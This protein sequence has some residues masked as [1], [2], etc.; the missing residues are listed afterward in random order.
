MNNYPLKG[1]NLSQRLFKQGEKLDVPKPN[2]MFS[3]AYK[4]L[5]TL[6]DLNSDPQPSNNMKDQMPA[7]LSQARMSTFYQ[8]NP[9]STLTSSKKYGVDTMGG[10]VIPDQPPGY[11]PGN[12]LR[13]N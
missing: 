10:E 7:F 4:N 2:N 3:D 8:D 1:E 13:R 12:I 9:W 6:S 5:S 11:R